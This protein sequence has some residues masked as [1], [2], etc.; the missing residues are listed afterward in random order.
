MIRFC[1]E[2]PLTFGQWIFASLCIVVL[3]CA[4][5]T[6][7]TGKEFP[8]IHPFYLVHFPLFFLS[9]L[10]TIIVFLHFFTQ[11]DIV[12]VSK[13]AIY[14]FPL[15]LFPAIVDFI[16][17]LLTKKE[18]E[19][20]YITENVGL[21]FINFFNP[22]FR[23]ADFPL[24]LRLEIALATLGSFVY[25]FLKRRKVFLSLGG[26]FFIFATCFF[27]IAIP[28]IFINTCVFV[29]P[30]L[31]TAVHFLRNLLG[32]GS[33]GSEVVS[34]GV[35]L[36]QNLMIV[37]LF[38]AFVTVV[39]W[40]YRYDRNK[41]LALVRN[42]RWTR[43]LHY[44]LLAVLGLLFY[45]LNT[46]NNDY[47]LFLKVFGILASIFF[48]FQF[49]VVTNDVVDVECDKVSNTD[50]PLVTQV[51]GKEE[52]SKV[53]FVYLA[54]AFLFSLWVGDAC[55]MMTMIFVA[56]YAVYSLPPFRIKKFFLTSSLIIGSEAL[57]AFLIGQLS[58]QAESS[59]NFAY[60]PIWFLVFI[61]FFLSS[62]IKD[63]K[64]IEGDKCAHVYSLPVL[65]GA[66][67]ARALIA[68]CVFVSY[69]IIPLV[70]RLTVVVR[71]PFFLLPFSFLYGALNFFYIQRS[72]AKEKNIFLFYFF[73]TFL[74]IVL[75]RR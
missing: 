18:M 1:E 52:Y 35:F 15:I 14:F 26:A 65:L 12:K 41:W 39:V 11:T 9:L 43:S 6:V 8:F 33:R 54:F 45:L 4:F 10:L 66:R 64:D 31:H 73:Y 17:I 25:I 38:V 46:G 16:F 57:M 74:L 75:I 55:F 67:K 2:S 5:E 29:T 56:F 40:Y 59:L 47:F 51:I 49:S 21:N 37:E 58:L 71:I 23:I 32:L 3:R 7:M 61:V 53:G 48:A 72:G 13:L 68:F 20:F 44:M 70:L 50:R 28:G 62:S 27:Y 60:A 19:Y 36:D 69:A 34:E 63:L 24:T 22:F 42:L 30:F